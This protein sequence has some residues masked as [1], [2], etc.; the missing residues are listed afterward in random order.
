MD[1]VK[2]QK[3]ILLPFYNAWGVQFWIFNVSAIQGTQ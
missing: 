3:F 2:S 1:N